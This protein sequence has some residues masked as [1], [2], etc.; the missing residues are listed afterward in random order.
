MFGYYCFWIFG[1]VCRYW[2]G[3]FVDLYVLECG[4]AVLRD[5]VNCGFGRIV[6]FWYRVVGFMYLGWVLMGSIVC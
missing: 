1:G 3:G 6:C 4:V 2:L 5:S